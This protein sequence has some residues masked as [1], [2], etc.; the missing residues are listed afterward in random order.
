[1]DQLT[2]DGI[3]KELAEMR[4][5]E[6]GNI[7]YELHFILPKDKAKE[8]QATSLITLHKN[9]NN[10]PLILDFKVDQPR[11]NNVIVNNQ[12][13]EV[14]VKNEHIIIDKEHLKEGE[15]KISYQFI[16]G[17]Q[18]LNRKENYMY[19]L[20]VPDRA[21]TLFPCFDQP[22]LKATYQ[23]SLDLP[24]DWKAIAGEYGKEVE[25]EDRKIIQFGKTKKISTYLFSFV[26][27]EFKE[28]IFK[29]N[30]LEFHMLHMEEDSKIKANKDA[31]FHLHKKS[32]AWLTEYTNIPLPFNKLDFALI[33]PFQYGGMEHVG[34]IQYRAS[35]LILDENAN[36]TQK[37]QRAKLIAHEVAHMWFGNLVT[38]KWFDD[39]WLKEVFA[40]FIAAKAV[41]PEYPEIN[42]DL[43]FYLAHQNKAYVVDRTDGRHAIQ[44]GLDN[45]N[46]AGTLYGAIIYSKAPVVMSQLE[47]MVGEEQLK[48]G[49]RSYLKNYSYGN[50]TFDN[51]IDEIAK[52]S[53]INL[54]SWANE[55]VKKKRM[56]RVSFSYENKMLKIKYFNPAL[57]Q[58]I[59]INNQWYLLDDKDLLIDLPEGSF[60]LDQSCKGYGYFKLGYDIT[61]TI[62][63]NIN[64]YTDAERGIAY[65]TLYENF[66]NKNV[67]YPKDYMPFLIQQLSIE[68]NSLLHNML[69]SQFK[70][71]YWFYFNEEQRINFTNEYQSDF[72]RLMA[73]AKTKPL[74]S[75][76][77][78]VVS[79]FQQN[80]T[81]LSFFIPYLTGK[82]KDIKLSD[83]EKVHLFHYLR[84]QGLRDKG[85][86]KT[87]SESISSTYYKDLFAYLLPTTS[88][89]ELL[90]RGYVINLG[91]QKE[92]ENETWVEYGLYYINHP[93]QA[94][95]TIEYI[96]ITL[97]YLPKVQETGDIFFPYNYLRNSIGMR[98]E[99]SVLSRTNQFI[100]QLQS[101]KM[102]TKLI[103]KIKQ[104]L[105]P[106]KRRSGQ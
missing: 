69:L 91:L 20:L 80:E 64:K 94:K 96:P 58:K 57:Q 6:L 92:R 61:S 22:D 55:W 45:L 105:D 23:L 41:A 73:K 31:I 1:M 9:T 37:M 8:I 50:A 95:E 62:Q 14:T 42:H 32:L 30:G 5:Q 87:V 3:T 27:G 103:N 39:V 68:Q 48:M 52:A 49:L 15:N 44:Q 47:L 67:L 26:A 38:M 21:R 18:S 99:K 33:P 97:S 29:E 88:D 56:P 28:E 25:N 4:F 83:K 71:V 81:T 98:T 75:F 19:T 106:I 65:G 54:K 60:P 72:I 84:M 104:N 16:A 7:N 78:K 17:D 12:K 79:N 100:Y 90:K 46:L 36:D 77:F 53:N 74:K 40:N 89:I 10:Y 24:K 34:A 66:L 13:I 51:L 85:I 2:S 102:D 59:Q 63:K 93:L 86:Q 101:Q 82:S 35:S 43:Q 70:E 11:I 76:Y